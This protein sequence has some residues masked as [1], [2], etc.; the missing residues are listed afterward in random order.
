MNQPDRR[1]RAPPNERGRSGIRPAAPRNTVLA[2][3]GTANDTTVRPF[4][5][6]YQKHSGVMLEYGR[7]ADRDEADRVAGLLRWAGAVAHVDEKPR[8]GAI[9]AS[10]ARNPDDL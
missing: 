8:A 7:Y 9:A 6:R 3:S 10:V 1:G 5:V 4:V 2:R